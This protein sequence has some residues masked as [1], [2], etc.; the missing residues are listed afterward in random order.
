[1]LIDRSLN[2]ENENVHKVLAE[3]LPAFCMSASVAAPVAVDGTVCLRAV[4][5]YQLAIR[6]GILGV[7][8]PA[9]EGAFRWPISGL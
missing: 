8:H 5:L 1:V 7:N 2:D 9:D 6:Y 3:A 4:W